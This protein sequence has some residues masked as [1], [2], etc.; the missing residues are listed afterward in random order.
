MVPVD[1]SGVG[2]V[3]AGQVDERGICGCGRLGCQLYYYVSKVVGSFQCKY[4]H[5]TNDTVVAVP[6]ESVVVG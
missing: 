2:I 6:L 4:L 3:L 1:L 5:Y